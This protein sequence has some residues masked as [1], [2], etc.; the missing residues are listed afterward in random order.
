MKDFLPYIVSIVCAI[1][2]GIT[3]FAVSKRAFKEDIKK[4]EKQHELDIEKAREKFAMEKE[5]LELEYKYQ[6]ELQQKEAE[7]K[8]GGEIMSTIISKAMEN[9]EIQK[10]ISQGVRKGKSNK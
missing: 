8:M 10:Q 2:S 9:P 7:N 4:L 6:I 3:S 5:K 1:I